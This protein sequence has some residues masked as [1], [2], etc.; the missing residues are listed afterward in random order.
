[1]RSLLPEFLSH[2]ETTLQSRG[3]ENDTAVK[4]IDLGCGTGRNTVQL[5]QTIGS[6]TD[7]D[8]NV[9]QNAEII[10]LDAS[11]GMLDVAREAVTCFSAGT[12]GGNKKP[13]VT[14]SQFDLLEEDD[15]TPT[16]KADGM[17]S[18]LVLEHIPLNTYFSIAAKLLHPGA[19]F[20][21]SNMHADMGKLSQ[22]GF[23]DPATKTKIRPMRSYA[24]EIGD[25]LGEAAK[26]GFEVVP[27]SNS[28]TGVVERA[29][30]EDILGTLGQRAS[31]YVGVTVW[32]GVCFR[33]K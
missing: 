30:T 27:L 3:K 32:F 8:E 5:L 19:Y 23:V 24:H 12:T 4:L 6:R 15:S 2:V 26:A 7:N 28:S 21:V 17:I 14:L 20:L 18:T 33:K 22:A 1:M 25:V 10:G 9:F 11:N 29:V 16:T 31:K 13:N